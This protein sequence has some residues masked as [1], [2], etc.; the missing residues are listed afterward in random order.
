MSINIAFDLDDTILNFASNFWAW[1]KQRYGWYIPKNQ[2]KM[3]N[4]IKLAR[5]LGY[6]LDLNLI[7]TRITEFINNNAHKKAKPFS[8]AVNILNRLKHLPKH[9]KIF[10]KL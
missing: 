3:Y 6:Y 5:N 8:N 4:W 10:I 1:H 7:E 9:G 2:L